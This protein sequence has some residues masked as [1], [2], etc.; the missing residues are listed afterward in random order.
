MCE[1]I[2]L[3]FINGSLVIIFRVFVAQKT[4]SEMYVAP[5][6]F[7]FSDFLLVLLILDDFAD[8][9]DS[10]DSGDALMLLMR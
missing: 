2:L 9:A 10:A 3:I 5:T 1:P 4:T 8:F 6:T 7:I